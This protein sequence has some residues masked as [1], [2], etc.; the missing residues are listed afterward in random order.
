MATT[1]SKEVQQSRDMTSC[2]NPMEDVVSSLI[3]SQTKGND[4]VRDRVFCIGVR[5]LEGH[6]FFL[7]HRE[8][9]GDLVVRNGRQ[10]KRR[11]KGR[12]SGRQQ[13]RRKRR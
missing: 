12:E 4:I 9:K 8:L 13:G 6:R 5:A 2:S 10:R 7:F 11:G 1:D 3:D